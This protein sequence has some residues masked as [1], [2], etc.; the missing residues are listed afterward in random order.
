MSLFESGFD[1]YIKAYEYESNV[2]PCLKKIPTITKNPE[3]CEYG[4]TFID[5]SDIY[6]VKHKSTSPNLLAGFI[7]LEKNAT[8]E[9][10]RLINNYINASSHL[11]YI[12]KGDCEIFLND[13]YKN[14]DNGKGEKYN[15]SSENIFVSPFFDY[16]TIKNI[17]TEDLYIYYINDSPLINYTGS[18][19]VKRIFKTAIYSK[20]FIQENLIKLSNPNNNRKGILLSNKDTEDIGINT[21]TPVLWSLYNEL[22]PKTNQRPH[23]HNSVALD[24]C[25][26]CEDLEIL[27]LKMIYLFQATE[28]WFL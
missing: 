23:R 8:F 20:Q 15:I 11:F 16:L 7:K 19:T 13:E 3:D 5:F 1:D 10:N 9:E 26:K 25:V 28:G 14:Y 4:I 17:G 21:I 18:I 27:I 2:N 22:P 12:I 6:N 24:L